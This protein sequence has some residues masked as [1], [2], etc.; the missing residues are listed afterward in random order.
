M[1]PT[2]LT[3]LLDELRSLPAETEW[4]EFK[5]AQ[6]SHDTEKTGQY[7]SAL[8]NEANLKG[9]KFGWLVFGVQDQSHRIVGSQ[10]RPHR[11]HLDSLKRDIADQTSPRLTFE[12]IHEVSTPEGRVVLFQIPAALRGVPTAWK[13]HY[14][15]RDGS[16]LGPLGLV[17]IEQ[18]RVQGRRDDW[19][20]RVPASASFDDLD[21]RAIAFARVQ[22]KVKHPKLAGEVDSWDV[23]TFLN[24][25]KVA[26]AGRVTHTALLLLGREEAAHHLSPAVAR[27]SWILRAVG[28][29]EKDYAHY[30]PPFI[31]NV[32]EAY[33][34]VRNLTVRVP[35][36]GTLYPDEISKYDDW[37][38]REALHNCI[39]HQDYAQGGRIN[40][41]EEDDSLLFTNR[42]HFIPESIEKVLER[43]APEEQ[44]RNP[45][46][47]QAMVELNMIDTIGS[48]IK[49]MFR[50]QKERFLPMP[51]YDLSD[52][53]RVKVRVIGKI[54]DERFTRLLI[55]D[56]GLPLEDVIALDKVQKRRPID[57]E[58]YRLLK[59]KGLIEGLKSAPY[60]SAAV[61]EVTGQEADYLHKKGFDK[62]DCKR[63]VVDYLKQFG[64]AVRRK[65]EEV[66][67]PVLSA[68]LSEQQKRDFVKNLIQEMK[69]D[70]TIFKSHGERSDAVWVLSKTD[71]ESAR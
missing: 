71:D 15:G 1:T 49:R 62:A 8:S 51:D 21:P 45:F 50:R 12:D 9:H 58:V 55:Y 37:V 56:T 64:S 44:Y 63:K 11:P 31:L 57:N 29:V 43:D 30:G 10:Y 18:I 26:I 61:A 13:G 48:G 2:E 39:A 34:K 16:S 28:G 32:N 24:K 54:L 3:A 38:V 22:Y 69:L 60:I 35:G 52:P 6:N 5:H 19:S 25:A 46:L 33:K 20:I 41:V 53:Q 27:I 14:Y 4:V 59:R 40:F 23:T 47:V 42:G 36:A 66:L 68:A 7:F 67:L 65:L 70:G 17:E